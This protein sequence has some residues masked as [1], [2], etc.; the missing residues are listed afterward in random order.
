MVL[1]MLVISNHRLALSSKLLAPACQIKTPHFI[2]ITCSSPETLQVN[3]DSEKDCF[4]TFSRETA[5]F[6]AVKKDWIP[7]SSPE[8]TQVTDNW[9][10]FHKYCRSNIQRKELSVS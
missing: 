6:Y 5:D 4:E 9:F 10:N 8:E 1:Y 2:M 7:P 3:W